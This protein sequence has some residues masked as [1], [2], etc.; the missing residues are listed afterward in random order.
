MTEPTGEQP[1][2][3]VVRG[4]P[5]AEEL[6][7]ITTT[8]AARARQRAAAAATT[9][10]HPRPPWGAPEASLRRMPTP[11]PDAWRRSMHPG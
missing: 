3:H 10:A 2:L 1:H 6:A 4:E 9:T 5:T 8:L 11:G 7:A